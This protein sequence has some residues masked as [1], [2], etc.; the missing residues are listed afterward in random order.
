[1]SQFVMVYLGGDHP[2]SLVEGEQHFW[3]SELWH[4]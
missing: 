3:D 2:S 4:M 1:M